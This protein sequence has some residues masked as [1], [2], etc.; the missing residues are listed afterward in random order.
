MLGGMVERIDVAM[1]PA[2]ALAIGADA[3]LV[4][5]QLRA[6]T[7]IA[8]LFEAGL[9]RLTVV[10]DIVAARERAA[11]TGALLFG[12]VGGLAPDGFDYGNSPVEA[13]DAAVADREAVL[14]TSNGTRAL[15]ALGGRGE[16][17]A[18]ALANISASCRSVVA[19]KRVAVVCAGTE[20][21]TRFTL[22]DY[23]AAGALVATL[24]RQ[25]PEAELGDA[26]TLAFELAERGDVDRLVRAAAH[27]LAT[28]ALGFGPDID[29]AMQCDTSRAVPRVVAC[30]SGWAA[31][32]DRPRS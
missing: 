25:S 28:E 24:R 7:T 20:L 15:C 10:D 19:A 26:A 4:V 1:V 2:E 9:R 6:T 3:Y 23:A 30:G 22:E 31:L 17:V 12:E 11:E 32:E 5:D 8:T 29:F 16:V 14:F 27:A 18:A 21:G 13:R